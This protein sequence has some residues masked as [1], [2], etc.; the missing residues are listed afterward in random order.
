M[1]IQKRVDLTGDTINQ[2]IQ[3]CPTEC[4]AMFNGV[5][6]CIASASNTTAPPSDAC[7]AAVCTVSLTIRRA[8]ESSSLPIDASI[9]T[10]RVDKSTMY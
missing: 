5:A 2:I 10:D 8:L 1:E 7:I 3:G 4:S 9:S 6:P